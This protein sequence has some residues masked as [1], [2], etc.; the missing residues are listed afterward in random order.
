MTVMLAYRQWNTSQWQIPLADELKE[1]M[2]QEDPIDTQK[3]QET[4]DRD[5]LGLKTFNDP[6][7]DTMDSSSHRTVLG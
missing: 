3:S 2:D 1:I 6:F 7:W 5:P 4:V